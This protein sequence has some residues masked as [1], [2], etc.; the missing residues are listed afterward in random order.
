MKVKYY[1]ICT[2]VFTI[3]TNNYLSAQTDEE[4]FRWRNNAQAAVCLTFDDGLD[5]HL[6]YAM[7]L[8]DSFQLKGSFY[9]TGNSPSL[10]NRLKEWQML[11]KNGHELGNHTLFH[12]CDGK[13]HDWVRPE[14]DLSKY[15]KN[16]IRSE[17]YTANTL[18]TAVD[19]KTERTFA[20]TCSNYKIAGD[21][22]YVE[23]VR[24]LFVAARCDGSMPTRM[25]SLDLHFMPSWMVDNNT[26]KELIDYV[27]RAKEN[28]TIA[29]IMFH[30]VG[31]G[32]LNVSTDAFSELLAYLKSN[33]NDYWVETFKTITDYI[34]V[35]RAKN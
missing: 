1:F 31:G 18:L 22:S 28:G 6:D 7:P 11:V 34:A 19:G 33:E 26:G 15:T 12:P 4:K 20:Y 30:N 2:L 13:T 32:Y 3:I 29:I 27:K 23:V 9:C 17:L 5:S 24:D 8:L 21:S 10:Q 25:D 16:Q 35:Q 14:Y